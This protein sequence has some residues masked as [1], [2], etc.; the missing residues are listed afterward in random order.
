QVRGNLRQGDA[1]LRHHVTVA[2]RHRL[3]F[4]RIE[5]YGDAERCADIVLTAVAGTNSASHV[6][7]DDVLHSQ[8]LSEL[9]GGANQHFLTGQREDGGLDG[10][11]ARIETQ[12]GAL[13]DATLRVRSLILL[14]SFHEE[15]H[16]GAGK[17]GRGL[18]N[19][20]RVAFTRLL[21]E[22]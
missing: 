1:F 21:I 20:R 18:D 10:S 8:L 17:T 22:V 14:V 11:Q 7:L 13:I 12:D 3:V 16:E 4:E 2:D 19:V 5:V 15:S 6:V 9:L